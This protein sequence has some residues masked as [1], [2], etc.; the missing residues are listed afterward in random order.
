ME[1]NVYL[2][3]WYGPFSDINSARE[4]NK[5]T[6]IPC[7]LYLISGMKKHAKTSIH[8]YIGETERRIITNRFMDKGH[9]IND[10]SRL[11]ELWVGTFINKK[12]THKDIMT[13]EKMMISY[14]VGEIGEEKML[15]KINFSLPNSNVYVISEWIKPDT[16]RAWSNLPKNSPGNIMA[17]VIVN[18]VTDQAFNYYLYTAKKL[19][20]QERK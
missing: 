2:I 14:F 20:R 15:N 4:W 5:E 11:K 12:V 3:R 8:Y 13:A 10:F 6:Q 7:N 17:D 18:K 9:H 16:A 1:R 19:K